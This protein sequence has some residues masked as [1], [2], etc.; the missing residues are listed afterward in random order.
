M[1]FKESETGIVNCS[2][3]NRLWLVLLLMG[4]FG[5]Y[6]LPAQVTATFQGLG[7]LPGGIFSSQANAVSADGLVV[8]GSGN[9]ATGVEAFRWTQADGMIS[10]GFL[11]GG[12]SSVALG[13]SANGHVVVGGS[14]SVSGQEAFRWTPVDGMVGLGDLPGGDFFS[15]A[16]D[17]SD[18]GEIVV[19]RS[20]SDTHPTAE[21]SEAFIWT[22]VNGMVGLG[23]NIPITQ[24]TAVSADGFV[25][26]GDIIDGDTGLTEAFRWT[27]EEGLVGLGALNAGGSAA[28]DVSF[29]GNSVVGSSISDNVDNNPEAFRWLPDTGMFGLGDLPGGEFLSGA[30]GISDNTIIVGESSSSLGTEPFIWS[31]LYGMQSIR[32]LLEDFYGL[33]LIGWT[34][35]KVTDISSDGTAIVGSGINPSG[36]REGWIATIPN[37]ITLSSNE[38]N[39]QSFGIGETTIISLGIVN[40]G[41]P[42]T[43]DLYAGMLFP[44][45][46]TVL[47]FTFPGTTEG[48]TIDYS[49]LIPFA[50]GVDLSS[51]FT[52]DEPT[53][54]EYTWIGT[55][56]I[57]DFDHYFFYIAVVAPGAFDDGTRDP[58]DIIF[59]E[60]TS[61]H[62]IP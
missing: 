33:D 28:R 29:E 26:V 42:A 54:F 23:G 55:E 36:N 21:P 32:F 6:S 10:A 50:S 24:A 41:F 18:D 49:S 3:L 16:F 52:I 37:T 48:N 46:T 62:F 53:F 34:I 47:S 1:K 2:Y 51:P 44:D 19:G 31:N 5:V 8:V 7:D 4:I 17:V 35:D 40:Y 45:L 58:G 59:L 13:V 12:N 22:P 61:F 57:A 11:P 9:S 60:T 15:R 25:V 39:H 14:T 20:H 56:Q 27:M 43:V 30:I 38:V